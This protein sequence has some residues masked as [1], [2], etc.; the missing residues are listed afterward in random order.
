M[1]PFELQKAIDGEPVVTRGGRPVT[2]L[3]FFEGTE[4]VSVVGVLE[5][6]VQ[7]WRKDGTYHDPRALAHY[8]VM[9]SAR[10]LFMVGEKA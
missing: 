4:D 6:R 7:M 8:R 9:P 3:K 10:D 1:K 2:Q 5:G